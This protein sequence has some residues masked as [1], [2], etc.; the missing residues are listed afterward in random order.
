MASS[1]ITLRD[2]MEWAK[3]LN[4]S[5]TSAIGNNAEPALSSA[6]IVIQTM[7][8]APFAW[9]WNRVMIGFVCTPGQQDYTVFNYLA[10]TAVKVGWYT[11]DDAGNSQVCTTAGTT[12]SSTPV[13]NHTKGGTT[14]D[15]SVVWTNQGSLNKPEVT[16]TYSF[17]WI[18]TASAQQ[19]STSDSRWM[20]METKQM[21]PLEEATAR[22]RYVAGQLTDTNGNITFRLSAVPDK[23]YP[24]VLTLQQKPALFTKTSQTWAPIPD[25]YS[26][27]Y[28]WGFLSL[29]WMYANDARWQ[30]ANAKFI[31]GLLGT[32]QGLTQTQINVFLANWQYIT[33]QPQSNQITMTQGAQAR[34]NG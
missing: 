2:T 33:G 22:P 31:A 28:N 19:V 12:N 26:H 6:N 30:I 4:F 7:L 14:T 21:L 20:E 16:N 27:I 10:S 34:G 15:G 18:E 24:V 5:R 32:N 25:E 29:M 17:A 13:W 11:V 1:S 23:A 3:Q 9:W 8:G